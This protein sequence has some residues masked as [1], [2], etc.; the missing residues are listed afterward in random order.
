M[1]REFTGLA[2]A[3]VAVGMSIAAASSRA[4]LLTSSTLTLDNFSAVT[5]QGTPGNVMSRAFPYSLDGQPWLTATFSG[6]PG[7]S[8]ATLTLTTGA[9]TGAPTDLLLTNWGFNSSIPAANINVTWGS[10]GGTNQHL[11][12]AGSTGLD[13]AGTFTFVLRATSPLVGIPA[14]TTEV[15]NITLTGGSTYNPAAFDLRTGSSNL[16]SAY[17]EAII[18]DTGGEDYV[19]DVPEPSRT[20]GVLGMLFTG[21][22][23]L[24]AVYAKGRMRTR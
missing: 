8:T 6:T 12:D 10:G 15:Y 21:A 19:A 11:A 5:V 24:D 1:R 17:S 4:D 16:V 14:N 13:S 20:V 18:Q 2:G 9:W 22:V 3:V 23:G 7:A